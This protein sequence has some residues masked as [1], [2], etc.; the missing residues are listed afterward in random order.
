MTAP[1]AY[2]P[3]GLDARRDR[4]EG[5]FV[6]R[7]WVESPYFACARAGGL[8]RLTPTQALLREYEKAEP[9]DALS[10]TFLRFRG[11]P[12]EQESVFLFCEAAKIAEVPECGR[13]AALNRALRQR[14]AVCL[15]EGGGGG[16]Y[17]CAAML[18]QIG[19][20]RI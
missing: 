10:R 16:L 1:R 8:W 20:E 18:Y 15:R 14:A 9:K 17:A 3:A 13:L 6:A 11:L 7:E 5:L 12:V 4:G 19:G 2:L